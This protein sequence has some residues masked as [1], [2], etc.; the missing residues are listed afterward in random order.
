MTTAGLDVPDLVAA[1]HV[2]RLF[3]CL[4]LGATAILVAL[5]L[6][7]HQIASAALII[8]GFGLGAAFLKAEFS[9]TASWRRFL[10]RGE[11]GG[12][13]GGLIVIAI[14]AVIVIPMAT[15]LPKY[16]GAIAPLG[17]SLAIGAFIFGIGMQ[18]GNGL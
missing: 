1:V 16:G 2:D 15:L 7:D 10:M 18:L 9:Y 11:A 6:L 3:L 4:A 17:P 13:L 12:L 14:C 8:G 5:V